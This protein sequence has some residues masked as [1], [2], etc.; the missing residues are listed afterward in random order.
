MYDRG[1]IL[2]DLA[3]VLILGGEAISDF[4][5]LKHLAPV[6]GPVP[7][8]PTVWRAL[9]EVGDVELA[10]VN[11]A[12]VEFR[13]YWWG[14][15]RDRPEGFPWLSVAGRELSGVTVLDLGRHGG[16]QRLTCAWHTF[17]SAESLAT[18]ANAGSWRVGV[19]EVCARVVR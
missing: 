7:S 9:E 19:F 10:R 5:A 13:R 12:G 8:T 4:Q 6:I 11:A 1:Q 2:T 15:L 14:L 18:R 3:L 16:V 17:L